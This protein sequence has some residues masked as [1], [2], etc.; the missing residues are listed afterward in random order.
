M[1]PVYVLRGRMVMQGVLA[2]HLYLELTDDEDDY[3]MDALAVGTFAIGTFTLW[4]PVLKAGLVGWAAT[5]VAAVTGTAV[6]ATV[7]A[8]APIA[9]GYVIGAVAGTAI[10]NEIWGEEGAQ[11]AL[12]FYSG[13]LLPGTEAP[14]LTDY[15]Y[16][17]KPTA[18]GGPVS[19]YDVAKKGVDLTVLSIR[20]A[21]D[22]FPRTRPR[23]S[24]WSPRWAWM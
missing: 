15:K 16:I 1:N 20:K 17:F 4:Q 10:A 19:A 24:P 9:A 8:V 13:G 21:I 5:E 6:G 2:T 7:T 14:D 23:Y 12:G 18:P 3:L 11:T 22:R